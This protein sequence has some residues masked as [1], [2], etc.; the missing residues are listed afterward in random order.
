MTDS[1]PSPIFEVA[2]SKAGA[3]EADVVSMMD[4]C[5]YGARPESM[6]LPA[7]LL[8]ACAARMH[9]AAEV[10]RCMMRGSV[11]FEN[12]DCTTARAKCSGV[13]FNTV[14]AGRLLA[15]ND[16]TK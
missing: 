6:W 12:A 13:K 4:V 5:A 11:V 1:R 2:E 7:G 8:F 15:L 10:L 14:Y 16:Y 9:T 3:A